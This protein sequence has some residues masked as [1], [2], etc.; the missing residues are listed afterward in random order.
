[1]NNFS[2]FFIF[3]VGSVFLY[4]PLTM[5]SQWTAEALAKEIET[6]RKGDQWSVGAITEEYL[7]NPIIKKAF[8]ATV[9]VGPASGIY[10]GKFNGKYVVATNSH[11][12]GGAK[13]CKESP[14][15]VLFNANIWS[16]TIKCLG[17]WPEIELAFLVVKP[18]DVN[19]W[20]EDQEEPGPAEYQRGEKAIVGR[21]T[22]LAFNSIPEF[23]AP[24]L[25]VG[26]GIAG[27]ASPDRD[28]PL[29]ISVPRITFDD[30]CRVLSQTGDVRKLYDPDTINPL[31]YSAWSFAMAC[32]ISHGASG[33]LIMNRNTGE[34]LG[35]NWT[36]TW[37][38]PGGQHI[39]SQEIA[40]ISRN[41][42]P[43]V[44]SRL[45]YAVPAFKAKEFLLNQIRTKKIVG[46]D[47]ALIKS[48][49]GK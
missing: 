42:T 33:S 39:T 38:K 6:Y 41:N 26:F 36:G 16:D 10:L 25:N 13:G 47:A 44:W 29:K 17:A 18:Y 49:L 22:N 28:N 45:N 20:D 15:K 32:D 8:D 2:R 12:V 27:D 43:E 21:A 5:A 4:A 48:V 40:D 3:L 46:P 1:M 24:L 9:S 23:E 37:T 31:K 34:I 35:V 30:D 19:G 14:P 11:V 7:Q